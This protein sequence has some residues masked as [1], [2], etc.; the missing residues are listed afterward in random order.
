MTLAY[1]RKSGNGGSNTRRFLPGARVFLVTQEPFSIETWV[2]Q[3]D[4]TVVR[5][6]EEKR[7]DAPPQ[8][9]NVGVKMPKNARV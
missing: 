3:S 6:N 1:G 9:L 4:G 7:R 2:R 5:E 8:L